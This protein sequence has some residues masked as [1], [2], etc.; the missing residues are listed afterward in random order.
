VSNPPFQQYRPSKE[1]DANVG[2]NF[3]PPFSPRV[4]S[5]FPDDVACQ[6]R[7]AL[8]E[9][10]ALTCLRDLVASGDHRLDTV[11][12]TLADSACRL[13]AA[14]GAAIAMWKDGA[15]I[16]RARSGEAAPP[17]GARLSADT[18][19]SGVCLRTGRVQICAD[20]ENDP[21][22]D[23]EVCRRLGFRSIVV[24]PIQGWRGINGIFEIFSTQPFAFTEHNITLLQQL[25]A[26]AERARAA[27]PHGAS[28][29]TPRPPSA[30]ERRKPSG[31][32]PASDRVGDVAGAFFGTRS[33]PLLLSIGLLAI[34]LLAF[35]FWLG[36][37]GADE[38]ESS[39]HGKVALSSG[40]SGVNNVP[41][42]AVGVP[43]VVKPSAVV[44][45]PSLTEPSLTE[46]TLK[47]PNNNPLSVG[48]SN[49][50]TSKQPVDNDPVWNPNP[51][52]ERL[53][54][55]NGK[56]SAG[57]PLKF[58]AKVDRIGRKKIAGNSPVDHS[59]SPRIEA[60]LLLPSD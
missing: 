32:L 57:M 31:L 26:L 49:N 17:L 48:D 18:G 3:D 2:R 27:K 36:W 23:V 10:T 5:R 33:R 41:L 42:S 7:H 59:H 38:V 29:T 22:V 40:T 8:D 44:A 28:A 25:A 6:S 15:M 20:T 50:R 4:F 11:L 52:G 1:R 21:I 16:C 46:P 13:T 53:F 56:P 39:A 24:L 55:S 34:S 12:E 35:A 19:I 14:T 54:S 43:D 60:P 51:G 37:Q 58:A 9:S 30:I 45:A 47:D